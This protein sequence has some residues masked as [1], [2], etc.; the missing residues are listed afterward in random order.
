[1]RDRIVDFAMSGAALDRDALVPILAGA[2]TAAAWRAVSGG[3]ELGFTFTRSKSDPDLARKDLG[4]ALEAVV[5]LA[6][7]EAALGDATRRLERDMDDAAFADQQALIMAKRQY[8]D[9]LAS[10]A[11]NE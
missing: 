8:H 2:E 11:G 5:G 4:L 10:L 1:M 3:D 7:I 6:E 9:R